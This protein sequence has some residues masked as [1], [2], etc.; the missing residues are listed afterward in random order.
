VLGD[1]TLPVLL[2]S[3]AQDPYLHQALIL[4]QLAQWIEEDITFDALESAV[5]S[6]KSAPKRDNSS[7]PLNVG[8]IASFLAKPEDWCSTWSGIVRKGKAL[9]FEQQPSELAPYFKARVFRSAEAC[10]GTAMA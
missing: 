8:F 4:R 6:A 9:G 3:A 7:A 1:L 5:I 10:I 2:P